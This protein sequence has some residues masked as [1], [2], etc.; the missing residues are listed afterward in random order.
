[1]KKILMLLIG[2]SMFCF[3]SLNASFASINDFKSDGTPGDFPVTLSKV[4][5]QNNSPGNS[6]LALSDK[7][8]FGMIVADSK[9]ILIPM[10][11]LAYDSYNGNNVVAVNMISGYKNHGDLYAIA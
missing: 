1:M 9:S 10:V 4:V 3:T 7:A 11:L 8:V 6:G 5:P 2:F